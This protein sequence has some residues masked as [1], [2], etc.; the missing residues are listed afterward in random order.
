MSL[1]VDLKVNPGVPFTICDCLYIHGFIYFYSCCCCCFLFFIR[2]MLA[3]R[4][5][6]G[7]IESLPLFREAKWIT[8]EIAPLANSCWLVHYFLPVFFF[9]I[10][11]VRSLYFSSCDYQGR[12][13]Y[14]YCALASSRA[15]PFFS[16]LFRQNMDPIFATL[17]K[18]L[19]F[20]TTTNAAE[21]VEIVN[22]FVSDDATDPESGQRPVFFS[23]MR[24]R[25]SRC[26]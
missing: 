9:S 18:M 15:L 16:F 1:R 10:R 12:G 14:S 24:P 5:F 2:M 21:N 23:N 11:F 4:C 17:P 13:K 19:I 20:A 8:I 26:C 25:A 6:C 7:K 22:S 3:F